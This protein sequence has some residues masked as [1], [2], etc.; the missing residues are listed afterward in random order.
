MSQY[1]D[2][3]PSA[4]YNI[5]HIV[6]LMLENRSFDNLL[7]WLY[8]D[9]DPPRDQYFDG[10]ND[11]LFNPLGNIDADG[12]PFTELVYV[13]RNGEAPKYGPYELTHKSYTVSYTMPDPDPGEGYRDTNQQLFGV[14]EVGSVYAPD[15]TNLG[16]ADNYRN[17]M[18]YGTYSF[19]DAPTDPRDIMAAYT[20]DPLPVLSGLAKSFCV[21]DQWYC[22]VPSQTWPNRAFA[23]AA[24]SD[25]NVNNRPDWV[26]SSRTIFDLL[27][28]AIDSGRSDLSWFVYS[29]TQDGEPFSLTQIMLSDEKQQRFSKNFLSINDFYTAAQNG[30]LPSYAFLEPQFSGEGQNDQHPPADVRPGETLIADVYDAVVNSS[31]WKETLLVI[32][33]DEH[34]GCYD[35]VA[36]P[37]ATPPEGGKYGI[38]DSIYGFRFNR[39]GLRVPAVVVSPWIESGTVGRPPGTPFDHTSL[40]A[41]I[42]NCFK[43]S[44]T[45]TARDAAASDLSCLLTLTAPRDDKPTV[46]PAAT[47]ETAQEVE[48]NLQREMA[49]FLETRT[50]QTRRSKESLHE[51]LLRS[52][53]KLTKK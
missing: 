19:G 7:G 47:D 9:E 8:D 21:C 1:L 20:T 41:S 44:E 11:Y 49:D 48:T 12:N 42:R 24:S 4:W 27:Q 37:G 31:Q 50:G 13:R 17:A 46:E 36:P 32:T 23:F 52:A 25:G 14:Y 53:A 10:L 39:F 28:D 16:F 5:H 3:N 6:V 51:F 30:N 35:H 38:P 40:I 26:V 15:P 18:L 29:G 45:L 43:L 2:P 33:Y 34:G 22:S